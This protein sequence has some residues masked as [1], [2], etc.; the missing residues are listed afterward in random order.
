MTYS[1]RLTAAGGSY[2]LR[3]QR[4]LALLAVLYYAGVRISEP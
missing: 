2:L 4:N 1:G 3:P